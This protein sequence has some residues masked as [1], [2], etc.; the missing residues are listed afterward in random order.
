MPDSNAQV[1]T[2]LP[3]GV[4]ASMDGDNRAVAARSARCVRSSS[5]TS[6]RHARAAVL[7]PRANQLD[8]FS[9]NDPRGA[10]V[11]RRSAVYFQ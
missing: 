4:R 10:A 5:A 9:E 7:S 6:S 3:A 1:L 2:L 8:P 11:K